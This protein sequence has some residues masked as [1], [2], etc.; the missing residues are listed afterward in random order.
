MI[1]NDSS[2]LFPY[3]EEKS[4][5]GGWL[6]ERYIQ[7]IWFEQKYLKPLQT[8]EGIS[9][10]VLSPGLWNTEAGPDFLKAHLR[11]GGQERRGDIELHLTEDSWY[12]HRHQEDPRYNH[13]MLHLFFWES[14]QSRPVLKQDG[15]QV[16]SFA[17][18]HFLTSPIKQIICLI[19]LDFYPYKTFGRKG[20]C[21]NQVFNCMSEQ[22][23]KAF[24]TSAAR[25]RLQQKQRYLAS[26]F[27][28]KSWQMIGGVALALGY[29]HNAEAFSELMMYLIQYREESFSLLLGIGMGCCGFFEER[30]EKRW[31]ASST[32]QELKTLWEGKKDEITNQTCL[33][34]D[35][36]R[37]FNHPIRRI[38]YLAKLLQDSTIENMWSNSWALWQREALRTPSM[39][40]LYECFL[41]QIPTYTDPYWNF[42]YT[43]EK[44]PQSHYLPLIGED[45]KAAILINTIFPLLMDEIQ[46]LGDLNLFEAFNRFYASIKGSKTS[47][48]RYLTYRFLEEN[49]QHLLNQAQLEQGAYQLHKDFCIHFEASCEGCPFVERDQELRK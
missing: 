8:P 20:K 21:A 40:Q 13:V 39:K 25:W 22:E 28:T 10:E 14:I 23:I 44:N 38:V 42:H 45:L 26:Q 48:T 24:F 6:K 46:S 30:F 37:P 43:F 2:L 33:R 49:Q 9:I 41:E 12:H 19:D 31:K 36:I 5:Q 17:L 3:V 16:I 11:I 1:Q 4:S 7:V 32:Y 34:L 18:E 35:R 47:K 27:S 15:S 29:K